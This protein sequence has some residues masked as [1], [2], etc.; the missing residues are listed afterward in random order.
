MLILQLF[1]LYDLILSNAFLIIPVWFSFHT[2]GARVSTSNVWSC[3]STGS[4]STKSK[5]GQEALKWWIRFCV[6][7]SRAWGNWHVILSVQPYWSHKRCLQFCLSYAKVKGWSKCAHS[8][9]EEKDVKQRPEGY[10]IISHTIS[11]ATN[12]ITLQIK[13]YIFHEMLLYCI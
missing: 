2:A 3:A 9:K 1:N 8:E 4:V 12:Y 10:V 6:Q 7:D 11:F 5:C 13:V